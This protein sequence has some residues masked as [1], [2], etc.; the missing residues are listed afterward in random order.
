MSTEPAAIWR[1]SSHSGNSGNCVQVASVAV[2]VVGIRDSKDV[3][4]GLLALGPEAWAA[5]TIAL[6]G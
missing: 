5:L 3:G 4:R 2:E 1:K 6:K